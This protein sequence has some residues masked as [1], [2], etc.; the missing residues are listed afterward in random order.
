MHH[1]LFRTARFTLCF[2][3][4]LL[5]AC[6]GASDP[7]E[8]ELVLP[9]QPVDE[10]PLSG[11]V[12]VSE[13]P[14]APSL[15][16]DTA[17]TFAVG[18]AYPTEFVALLPA[19]LYASCGML[20]GAVTWDEITGSSDAVEAALDDASRLA[21]T[22]RGPGSAQIVLS[23]EMV[24]S[25]PFGC[26][27]PVDVPVPFELRIATRAVIPSGARVEVPERCAN[28]VEARVA[29][30]P[31]GSRMEQFQ[32]AL[33]DDAGER[34]YV[35]NATEGAPVDVRVRGTFSQALVDDPPATLSELAFPATPGEVEIAPLA[36]TPLRVEV[37]DAA[38]VTDID[39]TF[40]LAGPAAG[41][42]PLE[43]GASYGADGWNQV[44]NWIAP[45][46]DETR[47]GADALC[48]PPA[49]AWFQLRSLTP[50]A[51]QTVPVPG[52][53]FGGTGGKRHFLDGDGTNTAA[54]LEADGTCT[55]SLEAPGFTN[56]KGL[57]RLLSA[58]FTNVDQLDDP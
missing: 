50:A 58:S 30:Q 8:V 21:L 45:M 18:G 38:R 23:G 36:G 40:H 11:V 26:E 3:P 34:M 7:S 9:M 27:V 53:H 46:V 6:S 19:P 55:L 56:G 15:T 32:L 20:E 29:A 13:T 47:V 12:E 37:V 17:L 51:C 42:I 57:A 10:G 48:S 14:G 35:A 44:D 54:Q 24:V 25:E 22:V 43:S 16:L 52:D 4:A 39:V 2:A 33:L 1:G 28:A 49:L 31:F 5:V 41:S